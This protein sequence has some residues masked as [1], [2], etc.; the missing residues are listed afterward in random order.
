MTTKTM[1][2]VIVALLGITMLMVLDMR[3]RYVF[4]GESLV[5]FGYLAWAIYATV[6]G[7]DL[8]GK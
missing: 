4:G 1:R 3:G 7:I 5:F 8:G 6:N 2:I